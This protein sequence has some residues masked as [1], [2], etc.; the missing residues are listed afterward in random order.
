[1]WFRGGRKE[2]GR[3]EKLNE[4]KTKTKTKS[5]QKKMGAS[6]RKQNGEK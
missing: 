5:E 6:K 2:R 3:R 1:M 4:R